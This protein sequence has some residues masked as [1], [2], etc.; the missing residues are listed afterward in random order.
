MRTLL[1]ALLTLLLL[2]PAYAQKTKSVLTTEINTNFADNTTGAITPAILRN[3]TIDM[4]NSCP[5]Y[6]GVNAQIGTSYTLTT[7][8]FGQLVTTNNAGA[9]T[10][11]LPQAGSNV[12]SLSFF[13]QNLG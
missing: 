1:A 4:I 9:V 13:T 12:S 5:Q 3:T 11:N 6:P 10:F 8:D 7:A 2:G